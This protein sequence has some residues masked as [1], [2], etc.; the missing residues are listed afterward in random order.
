MNISTW[1]SPP[2]RRLVGLTLVVVFHAFIIH[3]LTTG[4]AKRVIDV[5][6]APVEAKVI[7]ETNK[8]PPPAEIVPPPPRLEAA[9]PPPFIPPPEV[10][11]AAAP[12]VQNTITAITSTPPP[13]P[14]AI[15][16]I[17]PP[18]V[19]APPVQP[20]PPAPPVAPH[21]PVSA[22]VVCSN[23]A[24]VMGDAAYPPEAQRAG[25][26]K[27]EALIQF[28]LD[29]S[30]Q[31]KNIKVVRASHP[32]FARNSVR[33]VSEYKCQGQGHDVAVLVPFGYKIE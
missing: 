3:A 2:H 1:H 22:A 21:A 18:V 24:T 25:I 8:P 32:I 12:P 17:A 5:V 16:P 10:H 15:A 33:I 6:H 13:A 29:P 27:G 26:D 9:P 7:E 11:I 31:I 19:A 20:A 14:V 30:G 28:T 4:L 23:Y